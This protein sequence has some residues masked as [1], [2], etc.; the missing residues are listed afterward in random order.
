MTITPGEILRQT[1]AVLL[2]FDGPVC[3]VFAGLPAPIVATR[4]KDLVIGDGVALPS[5]I[6]ELDDPLMVLQR[7]ADIAPAL[8]DKLETTLLAS[9]VEA[10]TTAESTPGVREF[11]RACGEAGRPVAIVS[12]NS[13]PAIE[14]FLSLA[15]LGEWVEA[16]SGRPIGEPAQM[17]PHPGST[18][19]AC[20]ALGVEPE[21][22]V[23][24]GDSDFDMRAAQSAGTRSIGYASEPR[25]AESLIKAGAEAITDSMTELAEVAGGQPRERP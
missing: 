4:L 25:K 2:D 5:D 24:I 17:K 22:A 16:I 12:N 10:A 1:S 23:L 3:R 11:L 14:T 20:K 18:L 13:R 8:V 19:R 15:D 7:T 9:E 21:Q 6:A